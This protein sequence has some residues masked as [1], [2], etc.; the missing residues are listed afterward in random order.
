MQRTAS[1]AATKVLRVCHPPFDCESRL[2]GLAVADLVSLVNAFFR[3]LGSIALFLVSWAAGVGIYIAAMY[4][5]FGQR[6]EMT[7]P[8]NGDFRFVVI[9]SFVAF[10]LLFGGLYLP[11]LFGLRRWLRGVRP[12]WPFPVL[13]MLLGVVPT[14]AILAFWGGGMRAV[15]SP[16][17][18]LFYCMF[19]AAGAIV[20][21]GF[22][23]IYRSDTTI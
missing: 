18:A 3:V 6:M 4:V 21:F 11:L 17:S 9:S 8:R 22:R 7:S 1:K 14:A 20:G 23:V 16:E 5:F 12:I 15:L 2:F 13:A 19:M 10:A